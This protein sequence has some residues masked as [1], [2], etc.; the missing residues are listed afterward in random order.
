M[1]ANRIRFITG[2]MA[3]VMI[4]SNMATMTSF[5]A[6]PAQEAVQ[7]EE[8]ANTGNEDSAPAEDEAPAEETEENNEEAAP[9]EE[10]APAAETTEAAPAE[11]EAPAQETEQN[12]EAAAP[13]EQIAPAEETIPTAEAAPAVE[14]TDT[15][16]AE[17]TIPAEATAPAAETAETEETAETAL[18]EEA[19]LTEETATSELITADAPIEEAAMAEE[20]IA[21]DSVTEAALIEEAPEAIEDP[22][23]VTLLPGVPI[24]SLVA[25]ADQEA[26]N[27][28]AAPAKPEEI[29]VVARR[30][31]IAYDDGGYTLLEYYGNGDLAISFSE[32]APINYATE[33]IRETKYKDVI[34]AEAL[35]DI[36]VYCFYDLFDRGKGE[37]IIDHYLEDI[38]SMVEE[39]RKVEAERIAREK[40]EAERIEKEKEKEKAKAEFESVLKAQSDAM[41]KKIDR[42]VATLID[43]NKNSNSTTTYGDRLDAWETSMNLG[44]SAVENISTNPEYDE[45]QKLVRYANII[46]GENSW[47]TAKD[48]ILYKLE[49]ATQVFTGGTMADPEGRDIYDLAYD[50]T[51]H[52]SLF[53]GEVMQKN[54]NYL[55]VRVERFMTSCNVFLECLKAHKELN[56][57]TQ[58]QV[59]AMDEQTYTLYK[60]IKSTNHSIDS[61][62]NKVKNI[63]FGTGKDKEVYGKSIFENAQEYYAKDKTVYIKNGEA[64]TDLEDKLTVH[65]GKEYYDKKS[66]DVIDRAKHVRDDGNKHVKES[67]LK[68][69]DIKKIG[70]QAK[71]N[72]MTVKQYLAYCGFDVSDVQDEGMLVYRGFWERHGISLTAATGRLDG[73][74]MNDNKSS[75]STIYLKN[76]VYT[77]EWIE[78]KKEYYKNENTG[79]YYFKAVAE[80]K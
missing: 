14:T 33:E 15:A 32:K 62:V 4:M 70:E 2:G 69:D 51:A 16:P 28:E 19:G 30:S 50:T 43:N 17:E 13:T 3:A 23:N 75:D 31:Y 35:K 63:F 1:K 6:E 61:M 24:I 80:E 46:G 42:S 40:A 29:K 59:D 37:V 20:V 72:N 27:E 60:N 64:N 36:N 7:I 38:K 76:H 78:G 18:V 58:E 25:A 53:A 34:T 45:V 66:K 67:G 5:A 9:A 73:Y 55:Q 68:A 74:K 44:D 52:E 57:L 26:V 41:S 47:N 65:Y 10:T 22:A 11:N 21:A 79:Y 8:S 77:Q 12:I 71:A 54:E 56:E 49:Q 39:D 48:S